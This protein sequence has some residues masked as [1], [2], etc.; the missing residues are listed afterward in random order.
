[1]KKRKAK[2]PEF[3][4]FTRV[5]RRVLKHCILK[6]Y[7]VVIM[8]GIKPTALPWQDEEDDENDRY[9][10]DGALLVMDW[11]VGVPA[12]EIYIYSSA[13]RITSTIDELVARALLMKP[14]ECNFE[15]GDLT[16]YVCR[17]TPRE[18]PYVAT[19]YHAR[20]DAPEHDSLK[21]KRQWVGLE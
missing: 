1:M 7:D 16:I 18:A 8:N 14:A 19:Y 20:G 6:G 9:T 5:W 11:T 17:K 2:K 15:L 21:A 3:D 12:V 10:Q 4:H 13:R